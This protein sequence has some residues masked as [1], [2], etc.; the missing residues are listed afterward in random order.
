MPTGVIHNV[1]R[2]R[3]DNCPKWYQP[4]QPLRVSKRTGKLEHGFCCDN[5]RKEFHKHGGSY[6]KLKPYIA[7]EIR[8][9]IRE[10][11]P[12]SAEWIAGIEKRLSNIE[13]TL[14]SIQEAFSFKRSA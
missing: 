13:D 9:R 6:S 7:Q 1:P 2:R 5:C 11:R 14:R 10:L 4:S 8:S 12:D 3:C